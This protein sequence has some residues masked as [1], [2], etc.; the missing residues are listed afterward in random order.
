M[1]EEKKNY[2]SPV[3]LNL[4]EIS[5]G[6]GQLERCST[7]TGHK[8][9]CNSGWTPGGIGDNCRDGFGPNPPK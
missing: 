7:G 9:G 3:V 2:E 5:S 4:G 1:K 8:N 6:Y